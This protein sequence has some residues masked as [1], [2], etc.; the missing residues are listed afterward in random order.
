MTAESIH[1]DIQKFVEEVDS[2]AKNPRV[3]KM[4]LVVNGSL[5]L[6][7]RKP[8][9]YLFWPKFVRLKWMKKRNMVAEGVRLLAK[10]YDAEIVVSEVLK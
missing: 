8:R 6:H 10:Y 1:H 7:R 2:W 9:W 4:Q 3:S 5:L